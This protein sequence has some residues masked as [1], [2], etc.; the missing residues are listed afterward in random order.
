ML[1]AGKKMQV[2][3]SRVGLPEQEDSE[4]RNDMNY[5]IKDR[6]MYMKKVIKQ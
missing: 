4:Q 2:Q 3:K 1:Y 6:S 5:N